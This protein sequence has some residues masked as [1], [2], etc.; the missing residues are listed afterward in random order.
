MKSARIIFTNAI[1]SPHF[2]PLGQ[3]ITINYPL[4]IHSR[5]NAFSDLKV[6]SVA[7]QSGNSLSLATFEIL[8]LSILK[9]V[10]FV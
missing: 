1:A 2:V 10:S 6:Q 9:F 8:I 7:V 4:I 5:C 3:R